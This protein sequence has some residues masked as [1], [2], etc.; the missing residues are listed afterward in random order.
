MKY[1]IDRIEVD[2]CVLQNLKTGDIIKVKKELLP[3]N[4]CEKDI[5]IKKEE[6]YE[7]DL[8]EKEKQVELIKEKM[9]KLRENK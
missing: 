4:V 3:K 7:L 5:I 8:N 6:V 1:A 2:I 9:N